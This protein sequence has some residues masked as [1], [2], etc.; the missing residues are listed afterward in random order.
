MEVK[1][2]SEEIHKYLLDLMEVQKVSKK[3]NDPSNDF[4][5]ILKKDTKQTSL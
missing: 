2:L 1:Q 5:D 4:R 3:V